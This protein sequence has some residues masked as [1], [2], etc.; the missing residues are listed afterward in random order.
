MT[1][2]LRVNQPLWKVTETLIRANVFQRTAECSLSC[3]SRHSFA[4]N[5]SYPANFLCFLDGVTRKLDEG[6]KVELFYVDFGKVFNIVSH[7]LPLIKLKS[8]GIR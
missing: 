7:Q 5:G 3:Q 6:N 4:K 1:W 8:L 2:K